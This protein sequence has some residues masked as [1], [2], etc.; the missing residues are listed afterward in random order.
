MIKSTVDGMSISNSPSTSETRSHPRYAVPKV[1]FCSNGVRRFLTLTLN[2][3]LG[4]MKIETDDSLSK[5]EHFDIQLFLGRD[6][7][8]PKGKVAYSGFLSDSQSVSGIEF[9]E[10]SSRDYRLLQ[11]CL[12][13]IAE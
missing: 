4:G 6:S 11:R 7:I 1:V 5:G 13:A 2:L 8:L 3:G 10:L 12:A 9:M